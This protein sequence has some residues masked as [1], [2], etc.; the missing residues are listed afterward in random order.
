MNEVVKGGP[1]G[2]YCFA[3][4]RVESA[5]LISPVITGEEQQLKQMT[6]KGI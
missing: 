3:V 2:L 4:F 5:D 6:T 1:K